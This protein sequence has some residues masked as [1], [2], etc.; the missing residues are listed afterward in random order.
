M[1]SRLGGA[2]ASLEARTRGSRVEAPPAI[3]M[4]GCPRF[5]KA[6]L[7]CLGF[8][9]TSRARAPVATANIGRGSAIP[10]RSTTAAIKNERKAG[11]IPSDANEAWELSC[12][13]GPYLLHCCFHWRG[14]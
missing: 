7:S 10:D 14:A 4:G 8:H 12:G 3:Q 13:H 9:M 5:R 1:P 2:R 6:T 11:S